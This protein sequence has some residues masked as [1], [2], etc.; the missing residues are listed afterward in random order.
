MIQ[1]ADESVMQFI[2]SRGEKMLPFYRSMVIWKDLYTVW[3]GEIDWL[4]AARG[5]LTYSNELWTNRNLQRKGDAPS[6][7]EEAAF[8]RYVMLNDGVVKWEEFDHPT[9]GKIEIGGTKKNWGRTPPSFLLEE[10]CHRNMAF[11]LYHADQMPRLALGET[12]VEKLSDGLF[13]IWVTLE[14]Q[15]AIPTRLQQ[16]V[17][18]RIS[19]PDVV[20]LSGDQVRVLSSGVVTDRFFNRVTPVQRRPERVELEAIGGMGTVRAQFIVSGQGR[21]RVTIDSAR[22]GVRTREESLPR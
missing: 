16:D 3:G 8:L 10:E 12:K 13:R 22:G 20:T 4:Y 1:S 21:F 14:N 9:Y 2:A 7:E 17:R 15:R 5:I 19:P 11:T 18:H 6:R